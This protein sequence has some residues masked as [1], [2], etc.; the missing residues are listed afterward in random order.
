VDTDAGRDKLIGYIKDAIAMEQNVER[1]LDTMVETTD[2]A[3]L[4]ERFDRHRE[5]TRAQA[6]RLRAALEGHGESEST[7]KDVAGKAGAAMKGMLDTTRSDEIGK[8]VRDAYV[9]EHA[10]IAAHWLLERT[11]G[12]VGDERTAEVARANLREEEEM[13]QFLDGCWELAERSLQEVGA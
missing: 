4:R 13:A 1:Q 5:E 7:L 6:D 9:T 8:N 10:E 11:A 3:R 2:D 12:L